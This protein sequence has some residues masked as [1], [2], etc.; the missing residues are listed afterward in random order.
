M[1]EIRKGEEELAITIENNELQIELTDWFVCRS[2]SIRLDKE[3]VEQLKAILN[4]M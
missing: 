1:M 3:E 4:E 2:V